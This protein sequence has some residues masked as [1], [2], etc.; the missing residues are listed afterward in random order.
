[1]LTSFLESNFGQSLIKDAP[2]RLSNNLSSQQ[3]YA[4]DPSAWGGVPWQ[5]YPED[6]TSF[7]QQILADLNSGKSLQGGRHGSR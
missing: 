2:S 3:G 7:L 5:N 1:M 4:N 6:S